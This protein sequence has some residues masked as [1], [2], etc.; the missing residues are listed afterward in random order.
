[1]SKQDLIKTI[2]IVKSC[3]ANS[4]FKVEIDGNHIVTCTLSGKIRKNFIKI[5]TGDKVEIEL[6]PYD[7]TR[8]RITKRLG[9]N[10]NVYSV[11]HKIKR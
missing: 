11:Y 5:L 4:I 6:S 8:G 9:N 10:K 3:E 7:L 2:G 1:M